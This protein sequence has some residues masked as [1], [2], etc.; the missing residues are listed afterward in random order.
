MISVEWQVLDEAGKLDLYNIKDFEYKYSMTDFNARDKGETQ[1]DL[2]EVGN[3]VRLTFRKTNK[4][5][6]QAA[7][8]FDDPDKNT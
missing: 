5:K 1:K 8:C 7:W 2:G 6:P 3:M 4:Q